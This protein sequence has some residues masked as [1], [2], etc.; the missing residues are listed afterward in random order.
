MSTPPANRESLADAFRFFAGVQRD[1][2]SPLYAVL[3]EAIADDDGLLALAAEAQPGQPA[4]N[5]L[6]AAVHYL[7]LAGIS[8]P[9]CEY[10]ATCTDSPRDP[11]QAFAA[12][13]D[14]CEVHRDKLTPL[15]RTGLVQTNEIGR[16]ACLLPAFEVM[17]DLAGRQPLALVEIGPSAGLNLNW[18]KYACDYG[19]DGIYGDGDSSVR[20]R[21][22][23]RGELRPR[24]PLSSPA[25]ASRLGIDLHPI[26]T[27]DDDAVRWLR[28]LL[29]P[30]QR[31]RAERLNAALLVAREHPVELLPGDG[32]DL[33]TNVI[34]QTPKKM[35]VCVFHTHAACQMS[36]QGRARLRE[37]IQH[38]GAE[39]E[40]YQLSCEWLGGDAPRLELTRCGGGRPETTLL[41]LCDH[42]GRWIEW[43]DRSTATV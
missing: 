2:G 36:E 14:F 28:A 10:Y 42:H 34:Q 5:V 26:D 33:L 32:L 38:A 24:L 43:L 3:A 9:L 39:R 7:L 40:T 6:F 22:E 15:V 12:C 11:E 30:G 23:L 37:I 16:C 41:A 4:A 27:A 19:E 20:L 13:A 25:I 17:S 29:W 18:D 21:C 1:G 31:E 35:P 8:H